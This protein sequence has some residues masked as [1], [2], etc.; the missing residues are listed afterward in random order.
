MK[1]ILNW[2]LRESN[3]IYLYVGIISFMVLTIYGGSMVGFLSG[4]V[5]LC[6]ASVGV[7]MHYLRLKKLGKW[8]K[9]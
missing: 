3:Y 9:K 5:V 4:L 8:D 2:I 1:D 6:A 7:Y